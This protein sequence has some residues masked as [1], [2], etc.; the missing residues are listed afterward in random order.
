MLAD[1]Y[2]SR[3]LNLIQSFQ[4]NQTY[5][6]IGMTIRESNS[7]E[8]VWI[9]SSINLPR[10]MDVIGAFEIGATTYEIC[11]VVLGLQLNCVM[12]KGK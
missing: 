11:A 12:G 9:D 10:V 7:I 1:R 2:L 5:P 6:S 8:L 3:P 4:F